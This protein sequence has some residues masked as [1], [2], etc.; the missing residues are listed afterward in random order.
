MKI[1]K[2]DGKEWIV[3]VTS[4]SIERTKQLTGF[5][6]TKLFDDDLKIISGL[7]NDPLLLIRVLWC[8]LAS[9]SDSETERVAFCDSIRGAALEAAAKALVED[10]I[11]FFPNQRQQQIWRE[12]FE[13]LWKIVDKVQDQQAKA[14]QSV[15]EALQENSLESLMTR[16]SP[17][18]GSSAENSASTPAITP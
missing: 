7:F 13:N 17:N 16:S 4:G 8:S 9:W 3:N 18:A 6:M 14:M 5:E 10:F 12:M 2:S 1:F 11:D 15:T